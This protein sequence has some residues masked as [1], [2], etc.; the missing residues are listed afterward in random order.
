VDA[1]TAEPTTPPA[2]A[3]R[4]WALLA[5]GAG[6]MIAVA[7]VI[8]VLSLLRRYRGRDHT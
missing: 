7:A 2:G 8:A 4:L 5:A 3:A 6:L 1:Q